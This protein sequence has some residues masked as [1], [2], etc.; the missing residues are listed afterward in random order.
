MVIDK[1][2]PDVVVVDQLRN[3]IARGKVTKTEALENIAKE[4][5]GIFKEKDVVGVSVT[6]AGDSATDKAVLTMGDVDYSNTGIPG[7]CDVMIGLGMDPNGN[8]FATLAKNKI[9]GNHSTVAI[10]LDNEMCNVRSC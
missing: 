1:H 7:A 5:R 4:L 3:L 6:Q 8:T 9:S 10:T 2:N